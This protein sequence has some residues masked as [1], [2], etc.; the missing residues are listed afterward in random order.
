MRCACASG[1]CR[2]PAAALPALVPGVAVEG[3]EGEEGGFQQGDGQ[4]GEG[5]P[6]SYGAQGE[7]LACLDVNYHTRTQAE[8]A[9]G[10]Q[11]TE[12]VAEGHASQEHHEEGWRH[13]HG[14]GDG[15]H[16]DGASHVR[17]EPE[18]E[19]RHG[20]DAQQTGD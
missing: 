2:R 7:K 13:G 9:A 1:G 18:R 6:H 20:E 5:R 17:G 16:G 8:P 11:Q 4:R 15:K 3:Q 12:P 14:E 19:G 10:Q